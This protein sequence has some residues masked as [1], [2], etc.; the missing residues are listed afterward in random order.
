MTATLARPTAPPPPTDARPWLCPHCP[1]Q[2]GT[3]TPRGLVVL[4]PNPVFTADAILVRCPQ[5]RHRATFERDRLA[6]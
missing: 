1:Y 2:L 3:M 4:A 5:C 6:A